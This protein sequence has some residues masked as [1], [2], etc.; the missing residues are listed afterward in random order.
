MKK[1]L[2]EFCLRGMI[3]AGFGPLV[4]GTVYLVLYK[5]G[6]MESITIPQLCIGIFSITALVFVVGGVNVIH[7]VEQIPLMVAILIQGLILYGCYLVVYLINGWLIW[8][9]T[10]VLVFTGI[11][12]LAY[13]IIWIVIH[14][15]ARKNT[16]EVNEILKQKQQ[17]KRG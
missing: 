6:L 7:H 15:L 17:T 8:G 5:Q 10:P 9:L 16:A 2:R 11:F 14:S 1:M 12:V 3:A 13:F 4:L